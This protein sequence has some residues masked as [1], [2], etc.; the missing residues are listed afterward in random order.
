DFLSQTNQNQLQS[1]Q[2]I[3]DLVQGK[4]DSVQQVVLAVAKAEMSFQL[5]MEIRNKL[6]ESY[7][8]LMRMQF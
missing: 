8:E 7:N 2:A 3:E 1:N 5:F 6:V 4:T